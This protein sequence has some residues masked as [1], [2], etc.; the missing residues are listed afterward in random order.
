MTLQQIL[1]ILR[2]RWRT[3]LYSAALAACA[4]LAVSLLLPRQYTAATAVVIDVKSPDPIAGLVLPGMISPSYMATQVDIINSDRVARRVVERLRLDQDP[5][6]VE[7]WRAATQGQGDLTAWLA[8]RLQAGLDVKPSRESNVINIAFKAARPDAA[9]RI[10]NAFAQAFI[11]V[12]LELKVEPARQNA[13]WFEEQTG[14]LRARLETAQ[15]ALSAYRQ[16]AGIV[17][18][19]ET[20]DFETARLNELSSQ[21]ALAQ[22]QNAENR[23]KSRAAGGALAEILQNPLINNLKAD[24]ARLEA[25]LQESNVNLGRN[26]PQ[27]Q[28]AESELAALRA[29]L[30]SET[31]KIAA[32]VDT[33]Y[34]IGQQKESE[35]AAAIERQK[36]RV[37][38]LNRQRDDLSILVRDVE[39]A[40]RAFEGVSQ[41]SAQTRLE[42]LSVQTNAVVLSL[43][44]EPTDPSRPKTSLNVLVA[45]VLGSLLGAA[46]ALLLEFLDR[47]VRAAGDLARVDGVPLLAAIDHFADLPAAANPHRRRLRLSVGRTSLRPA[48]S[49]S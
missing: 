4:A 42:S 12:N 1:L 37:L 18:A 17:A 36:Q 38:G 30:D 29:R 44:A 33:A 35:L 46:F 47:R 22:G 19:E 49:T 25:K 39:S 20:L 43:A 3:V 48:R 24:V 8:S 23:G 10:A 41:R 7:Q 15:Q 9:A 6:L 21:L 40:Q 13:A 14:A 45:L 16:K 26:H 2:V 11:D 27:T 5:E 28:R 32:S 34:R 31:G